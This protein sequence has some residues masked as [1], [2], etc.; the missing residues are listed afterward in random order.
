MYSSKFPRRL[1]LTIGFMRCPRVCAT[2]VK[3]LLIL[4][5]SLII[6]LQRYHHSALWSPAGELL[7]RVS[8]AALGS[9]KPQTVE[10]ITRSKPCVVLRAQGFMVAPATRVVGE[11]YLTALHCMNGTKTTPLGD[12]KLDEQILILLDTKVWRAK[13]HRLPTVMT[14]P[15]TSF[16]QG[17]IF[18]STDSSEQLQLPEFVG[19]TPEH[20]VDSSW[21]SP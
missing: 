8:D 7:T 2:P 13:V 10:A 18:L 15:Q 21:L 9:A 1:V 14:E 19:R 17:I 4:V 3:R 11:D 16:T 6:T 12:L 20:P 5:P